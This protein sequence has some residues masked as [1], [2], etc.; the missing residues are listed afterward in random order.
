MNFD[1]GKDKLPTA[2]FGPS[3]ETPDL[4]WKLRAAN[5]VRGLAAPKLAPIRCIRMSFEN[6]IDRIPV[7][8]LGPRLVVLDSTSKPAPAN[9]AAGFRALAGA[10]TGLS[11][12]PRVA[13]NSEEETGTNLVA[14]TPGSVLGPTMLSSCMLRSTV[15]ISMV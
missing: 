9:L 6:C 14:P 10:P 13:R 15:G 12:L 8:N 4:P 7:S 11:V 1:I 3:R 5:L 2:N